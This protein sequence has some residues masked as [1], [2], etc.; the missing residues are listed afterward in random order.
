VPGKQVECL[1]QDD[2]VLAAV[3]G[4]AEPVAG[5]VEGGLD[6]LAPSSPRT[7]PSSVSSK[8]EKLACT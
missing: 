1:S 3:G 4:E 7:V 8:Q 5:A 6:R 2:A